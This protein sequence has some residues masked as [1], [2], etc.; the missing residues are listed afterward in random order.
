MNSQVRKTER[1]CTFYDAETKKYLGYCC[2]GEKIPVESL[3]ACTYYKTY[4][5]EVQ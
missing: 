5:R 2:N 3:D 1:I 4:V